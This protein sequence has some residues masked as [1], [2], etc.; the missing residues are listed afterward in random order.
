M[1]RPFDEAKTLST[2]PSALLIAK[3]ISKR[4]G[5]IVALDQVDLT[6]Q[7]GEIFG[8]IGP[9]GAG[10]TTFFDLLTGLTRPDQ[11]T[12]RFDDQPLPN[13]QAHRIVACGIART[14]Q[15][16]RLFGDASTLENV[17]VGH[18]A[19]TRSGLLASLLQTPSQREEEACALQTAMA[20][21][22]FVGLAQHAITPARNLSYGDQR[23]LEIARALAASP[24]LLALDEPAAGMNATETDALQ[25]LIEL[26]REEGITVLVIEHDMRLVMRMC[27]RIAVLDSGRKI[28]QGTPCEIRADEAVIE[29]Y[30][31]RSFA[32]G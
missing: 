18:H 32:H 12:V 20:A 8:L 28:A 5:G 19:R 26:I 4:F 10:K 22:A 1:S 25:R 27:D 2:M 6:V 9:N 23:R 24:R 17:M 14:F 11:G 13:G 16:I 31:G 21:L 7:T 30:L 15:N 29:A 3:G